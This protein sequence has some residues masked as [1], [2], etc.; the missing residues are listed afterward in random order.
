MKCRNCHGEIRP[1]DVYCNQCGVEV[2][3]RNNGPVRRKKRSFHDNADYKPLQK[4]FIQG[5]Y[6]EQE[7]P[8][9]PGA[10]YYDPDEAYDYGEYQAADYEEYETIEEGEKSIWGSLILFLFLALV[11]GFVVGLLIF[12]GGAQNFLSP[13]T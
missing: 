13:G 12:T 10:E 6:Q 11:V 5:E 2:S 7:D 9:Y 8:Y 1:G 3:A 4:K